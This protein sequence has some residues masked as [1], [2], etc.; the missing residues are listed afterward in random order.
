MFLVE[1]S[2]SV[3][4]A[5]SGALQLP[6]KCRFLDASWSFAM[7]V[8]RALRP[9]PGGERIVSCREAALSCVGQPLAV[10][11]SAGCRASCRRASAAALVT[12]S[13][14]RYGCF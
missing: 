6:A 10:L 8:G 14:E 11:G 2:A 1:A 3:R 12:Q 13:H 7:G 4:D 5:F 9:E